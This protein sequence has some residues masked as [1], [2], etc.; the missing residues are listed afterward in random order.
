MCAGQKPCRLMEHVLLNCRP[1]SP[2]KPF[3][4]GIADRFAKQPVMIAPRG[5]IETWVEICRSLTQTRYRNIR[6]KARIEPFEQS[7][8]CVCPVKIERSHLS[9]CVHARVRPASH[10]DR[11]FR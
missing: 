6:W 8:L 10:D 7:L 2:G 3:T 11:L 4:Q 5:C 9:G 1:H